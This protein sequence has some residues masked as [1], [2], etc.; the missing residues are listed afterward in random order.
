MS[1]HESLLE[2]ERE[3]TANLEEDLSL[4]ELEIDE[5]R[6][7][8][9]SLKSE[10]M[11]LETMVKYLL[12]DLRNMKEVNQEM[13]K[14]GKKMIQKIEEGEVEKHGFNYKEEDVQALRYNWYNIGMIHMNQ[15]IKRTLKTAKEL[16]VC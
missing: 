3:R 13:I 12:T 9:Q 7:E 1:Y 16:R 15:K 11:H 4:R 5:L 2:Y 10:K 8:V 14:E 6:E